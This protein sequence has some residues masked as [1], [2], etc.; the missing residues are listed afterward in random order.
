[1]AVQGYVKQLGSCPTSNPEGITTVT[2][3]FVV[4]FCN[5]F[6]TFITPDLRQPAPISR[7]CKSDTLVN[8]KTKQSK[9]A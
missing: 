1:M 9:M 4:V 2:F 3:T 6:M 7:K 5:S 8:S